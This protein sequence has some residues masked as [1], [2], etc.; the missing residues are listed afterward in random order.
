MGGGLKLP[1]HLGV[2]RHARNA[3]NDCLLAIDKSSIK[4]II[5]YV[6]ARFD[7]LLGSDLGI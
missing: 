6:E 3:K 4:A 7:G 2:V 5:W 1:L